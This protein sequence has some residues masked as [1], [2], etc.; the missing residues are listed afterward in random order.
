MSDEE[1]VEFISA[2]EY[3]PKELIDL[4]QDLQAKNPELNI[5]RDFFRKT[6]KVGDVHWIEHFSTFPLFKIA[7]GLAPTRT[8]AKEKRNFVRHRE[9]ADL[10]KYNKVKYNLNSVWKKESNKRY[11]TF[12]VGSDIHDLNCDPFF[13]RMFIEAAK[14]YN[15]EK[16]IF[17]GDLYDLPE[18][19]KYNSRP[20][21]HKIAE[22]VFWVSNFFADLREV[23]PDAEFNL[24]EGN[25]EL[26]LM[27][28]ILEK[29]SSTSELLDVN[30]MDIAQILGLNNYEVNYYSSADLG[31]FSDAD[32]KN[33]LKKNYYMFKNHIVFYHYP[34]GRNRF[35][36]PGISG[37]H[38]KFQVWSM[39][40]VTYGAYSWTQLG[41][42]CLR[43]AE[44]TDASSD[45]QNG[46]GIVHVDLENIKNT[47]VEYIDCT[48]DFCIM[49]GN[50]FI[51]NEKEKQLVV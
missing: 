31:T 49:N 28:N 13:R 21:E 5:S 43:V 12:L 33:E 8:A 11:Q 6:T 4:I 35:G 50:R 36:M 34:E 41:A 1:L 20:G 2:R 23:V 44:Y 48:Y 10:K 7:A 29:T 3:T 14:V 46:F 24:V 45:W 18:F 38:H 26:R 42:G 22:R 32:I 37:H 17:N 40:N 51:R 16:V 30:G 25:H 9:V 19:S 27:R 39:K 15:P 47:K